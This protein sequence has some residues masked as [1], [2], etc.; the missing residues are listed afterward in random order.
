MNGDASDTAIL[1]FFSPLKKT[2]L[3]RQEF[4]ILIDEHGNEQK[5]PFSAKY[6]YA[7]YVRKA[8][9]SICIFTKVIP[10]IYLKGAPERVWSLCTHVFHE[11]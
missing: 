5:L 1:K 4:P 9:N 2:E 6:K 7:L 3:I 11:G 10:K 8:E